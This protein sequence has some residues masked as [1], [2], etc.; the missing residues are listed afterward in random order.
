MSEYLNYT[1]EG[2]NQDTV[3]VQ[4]RVV[5]NRLLNQER[6]MNGEGGALIQLQ[7]Q[8]GFDIFLFGNPHVSFFDGGLTKKLIDS[9]F[10]TNDVTKP[11]RVRQDDI[12]IPKYEKLVY[13]SNPDYN[14]FS[15]ASNYH[16]PNTEI[17]H[18]FFKF[19]E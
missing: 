19:F 16:K 9:R 2:T 15:S 1:I 8:G 10:C 6:F 13:N 3:Y 4:N 18:E 7:A 12:P 14:W 5:N 11:F 17:N